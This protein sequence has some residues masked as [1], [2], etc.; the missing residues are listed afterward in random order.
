MEKEYYVYGLIDPR[1]N[2]YFYIGKGKGKRFSSHLNKNRQKKDRNYLKVNRIRDIESSGNSVKIEIIFSNLDEDIAYELEKVLIYRLGREILDEG[3]LSNLVPGG[4]RDY[5]QGVFYEKDYSGYFDNSKISIINQQKLQTFKKISNVDF[6][7]LEHIYIYN[8]FGKYLRTETLQDFFNLVIPKPIEV[9]RYKYLK[10][11]EL[12]IFYNDITNLNKDYNIF[13]KKHIENIYLSLDIPLSKYDIIDEKFHLKFDEIYR[14]KKQFEI[15]CYVDNV[16]RMI[17]KRDKNLISIN[18]F[19]SNGNKKS[20]RKTKNRKPIDV[21]FF[22]Y[23]NG[24]IKIKK[25]FHKRDNTF[26]ETIYYKNGNKK[27]YD[28]PK[29]WI[30]QM[31]FESGAINSIRTHK[32]GNILYNEKGEIIRKGY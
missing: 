5:A 3:I 25:E 12:P 29:K 21:E 18:S 22:W 13:S 17:V 20:F 14:K 27:Y 26:I 9:E 28:N 8:N 4:N 7:D 10:K 24:N 15:K 32:E 31:W 23:E 6:F 30:T 11:N 2:E 1:N 19:Y 16:V